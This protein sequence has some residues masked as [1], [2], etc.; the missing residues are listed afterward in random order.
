MG[1][2]SGIFGSSAKR[3]EARA[4]KAAGKANY[5][6]LMENSGM[7]ETANKENADLFAEK[8]ESFRSS[9]R[10]K[11]GMSG[12]RISRTGVKEVGEYALGV[13]EMDYKGH[14]DSTKEVK[15]FHFMESSNRRDDREDRKARKE[16]EG[17]AEAEKNGTVYV[18]PKDTH[19]VVDK[20]GSEVDT[21]DLKSDIEN[22][23]GKQ[24]DFQES[25]G[26]ALLAMQDTTDNLQK[27]LSRTYKQGMI[28]VYKE[29]QK[30]ETALTQANTNAAV[31]NSQA[32]A[33]LWGGIFDTALSV[34]TGGIL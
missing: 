17:R 2:F 29:R 22:Y 10:Q 33:S 24:T 34:G 15:N 25:G 18:P 7:L 31:A 32:N 27:D 20:K 11:L 30:A 26:S 21:L 14:A 6:L 1:L 12:V 4:I 8:G 19:T 13:E 9:Q 16:R 3:K 5:N 23:K 28:N